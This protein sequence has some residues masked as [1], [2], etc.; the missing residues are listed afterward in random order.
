MQFKDPKPA[1]DRLIV[2]VAQIE[3]SQRGIVLPDAQVA[4]YQAQ[5]GVVIEQGA[6]PYAPD[7]LVVFN[8]GSGLDISHLFDTAAMIRVLN[9]NDVILTLSKTALV[10]A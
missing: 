3:V 1:G 5:V 10:L 7:S 2:Q 6:S 8:K 4:A 9:T